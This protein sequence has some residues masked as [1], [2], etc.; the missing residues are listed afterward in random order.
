MFK[1]PIPPAIWASASANIVQP[2]AGKQAQGWVPGEQ[3]PASFFNWWQNAQGA[4]AD[5]AD[6]ALLIALSE[7]WRLN[8][9]LQDQA[10][11]LTCDGAPVVNWTGDWLA[12][13]VNGGVTNVYGGNADPAIAAVASPYVYGS[14][15]GFRGGVGDSYEWLLIGA[16]TGTRKIN[17]NGGGAITD[18]GVAAG[19]TRVWHSAA[20]NA[21][22]AGVAFGAT[23]S[24][25]LSETQSF[26]GRQSGEMQTASITETA[27]TGNFAGA[28]QRAVV[29]D[30][31]RTRFM[32]V[33]GNGA[34]MTS[35]DGTTWTAQGAHGLSGGGLLS[36]A[37]WPEADAFV[38]CAKNASGLWTVKYS[39][40]AGVT[41]TQAALAPFT[42]ANVIEVFWAYGAI[43][44]RGIDVNLRWSLNLDR[45]DWVTQP[46]NGGASVTYAF[47]GAFK[48]FV[49][50]RRSYAT[51]PW[52]QLFWVATNG[53]LAA[54]PPYQMITGIY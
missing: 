54:S 32:A 6:K 46:I 34:T 53:Y 48:H 47:R 18:I 4:F 3:P 33:F 31:V 16:S 51:Q 39:A 38:V 26:I 36:I 23:L 1:P 41:W 29:W 5:Y 27:G 42:S 22:S 12:M 43:W 28:M 14:T 49:S 11:V 30:D 37:Y 7:R 52:S 13:C 50:T 9:A 2:S 15:Q 40:D 21:G 44:M 10:F 20:T 19:S 24:V 17:F 8:I 25:F 35:T 45:S